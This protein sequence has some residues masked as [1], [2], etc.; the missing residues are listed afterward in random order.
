MPGQESRAMID[1]LQIADQLAEG[2]V[3]TRDQAERLARVSVRT[4]ARLW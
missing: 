2:G 1:T 4:A 3:F